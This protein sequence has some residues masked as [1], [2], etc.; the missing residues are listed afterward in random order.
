MFNSSNHN[1]NNNLHQTITHIETK[2]NN[3]LLYLKSPH[4]LTK[5]IDFITDTIPTPPNSTPILQITSQQP[6]QTAQQTL[7]HFNLNTQI[8]TNINTHR[9]HLITNNNHKITN[10]NKYKLEIIKYVSLNKKN[11]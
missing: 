10:L 6:N 2:K 7:H 3:M 4:T 8:L 5:N 9:L 11:K 1:N